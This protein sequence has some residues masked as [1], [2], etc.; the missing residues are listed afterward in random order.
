MRK[1]VFTQKG[2]GLVEAV[3]AIGILITGIISVV[4]LSQSNIAS[5]QGVAARLTAI[6]LAR[7]GVEAVR[8]MRDGNWLKG[9]TNVTGEDNAW[10]SGFSGAGDVTA[11][12]VLNAD[13][14]AWTLDFAPAS[15]T[16]NGTRLRRNQDRGLY[17]QSR[18][19]PIP[20]G[21]LASL[22][23][24]LLTIYSICRNRPGQ[25]ETYD[26]LTCSS[27]WDKVGI[28]VISRVE[29]QERGQAVG[30]EVEDWLYNWR[31]SFTPYVP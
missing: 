22:Y 13:S 27:G 9:R 29:W 25:Q 7:E 11:I 18:E 21:E 26:N 1:L 6:N 20:A 5:S 15:M 10:D 2:V 30:L 8:S 14:L 4:S 23:S 28:R 24:R 17:R 19:N 3:V 31:Y 16:D 12:A